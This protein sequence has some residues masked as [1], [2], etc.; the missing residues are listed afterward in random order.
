MLKRPRTLPSWMENKAKEKQPSKR[1]TKQKHVRAAFFCMNEKELVEAAVSYLSNVSCEDAVLLADQK[2][3]DTRMK[4]E[5]N[6]ST[7][8]RSTNLLMEEES[9][10][11]SG[12]QEIT[13]VSESDVDITEMGTVPYTTSP[14]HEGLEGQQCGAVQDDN[15]IM[16]VGLNAGKKD[17]PSQMAV[18]PDDALQLVREIFFS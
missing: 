16:D 2:V 10:D 17:L 9:S 13:C 18:E 12:I 11:C 8:K 5:E 7:K 6:S 15:R 4:M 3:V 14:Q 1:R